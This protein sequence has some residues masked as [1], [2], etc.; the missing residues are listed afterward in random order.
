MDAA[1]TAVHAMIYHCIQTRP[2]FI[3]IRKVGFVEQGS[4]DY[5]TT[6]ADMVTRSCTSRG[7]CGLASS[8]IASTY[9]AH[10]RM[11]L[12]FYIY[13]YCYAHRNIYDSAELN[14]FVK[15]DTNPS[16]I[17]RKITDDPVSDFVWDHNIGS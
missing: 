9:K 5:T 2:L 10:M 3:F 4:S 17:S 8:T 12:G 7:Q 11:A 6:M 15:A 13:I 14:L 1:I 16:T